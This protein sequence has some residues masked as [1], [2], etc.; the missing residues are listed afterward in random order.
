L[1]FIRVLFR[2]IAP[3]K[4]MP[5]TVPPTYHDA[6]LEFAPT[7]IAIISKKP[8]FLWPIGTASV[9]YYSF[10]SKTCC[11]DTPYLFYLPTGS[12][13]YYNLIPHMYILLLHYHIS[14]HNF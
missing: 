4:A 11:C 7:Q 13:A 3:A 5:A 12:S 2:S 1:E 8:I 6:L 14:F 9:A 10:V